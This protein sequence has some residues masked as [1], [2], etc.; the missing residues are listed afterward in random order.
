MLVQVEQRLPSGMRLMTHRRGREAFAAALAAFPEFVART[1]ALVA[2]PEWNVREVAAMA[3]GKSRRV[4]AL[5]V[6]M[7]NKFNFGC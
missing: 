1:A 4:L 2:R 3:L 5:Q 6:S 7:A